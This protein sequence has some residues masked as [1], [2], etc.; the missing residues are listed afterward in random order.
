[1]GTLRVIGFFLL[2]MSLI[3]CQGGRESA[4][5]ADPR[6]ES[7]GPQF[8]N[9]R[10]VIFIP[11]DENAT[12]NTLVATVDARPGD[13]IRFDCGYYE[14]SQG[15]VIQTTEDVTIE[16]CGIDKTV[17]S[18]K[19]S[20]LTPEGI[21]INNARGIVIRGL[22]VL[23]TAGDGIKLKGVDHGTLDH[24]RT[25]WSSGGGAH[26]EDPVDAENYG[27]AMKVA[28]TN[29]PTVA[30]DQTINQ[31]NPV[32]DTTSPDYVP[33]RETGRYGIYPV[34]SRNILVT[35]SESIGA[36]DA[37]IYVGQTTNAIIR[38]SR[39]AYNVMGFEIENVQG[40]E[41]DNNIAE[42]NT[43]GFLIYDLDGLD[44]YGYGS[45]AINNVS[46]MNNTY[47]F[48]SGGFVGNVPA[49][50]GFITLSYDRMDIY[51]NR[52]ENNNTGGF[53]W[54][55]YALF[56]ASD[57]PSETQIDYFTEGV[58][59]YDN[60][61]VNN[62]NQLSPP[63]YDTLIASQG[64]DV[65]TAMPF[66]VGIKNAIALS[67][68]TTVPN[69]DPE[70]LT[71][72]TGLLS[73]AG[74][75][76]GHILW[77][78][79]LDSY[80][81]DCPYPTD[82]DG[83]PVPQAEYAPGKPEYRNSHGNPDCRYNAYKFDTKASGAPRIEPDWLGCIADSNDFS[84][85]SI[86]FTNFHGT[87]G[88]ELLVDQN[89]IDPARLATLAASHDMSAFDCQTRFGHMLDPVP[90]V[91]I[92]P[93]QP[94][95]AIAPA[96]TDEYVA[97]LCDADVGRNVNFDAA[98]EVNCPKLQDYNLFDDPEDPTS[99]PLSNGVP[100]VLN[101][102][103][104]TEYAVK[105]RVAYLPP[106]KK[107]QYRDYG[108][109]SVN[110]GILWPTGT[111]LAK[112]FSTADEEKGTETP[113]ETRLMIKRRNPDGSQYWTGMA[114]IWTEK[115]GQWSADLSKSGALL[116]ISWNYTD[117]ATGVK[118]KGSTDEYVVPHIN[119]CITCHGNDDQEVGSAPVGPKVR[120]LNRPYRSE[121]PFDTAQANHSVAGVNQIK[122]LCDNNLMIDCP[123]LVIDPTT[124]NAVNIER[125]P[126]FNLPGDSGH[127]AGSDADVEA[128]AR[129]YLEVNCAHCHNPKGAASNT[130]VYFDVFRKVDIQYGICKGPTAAGGEGSGGRPHDIHPGDA[131]Q[132]IIPF[133][134][135][136]LATS[137]AARMPPLARSVV[138]EE[139]VQLIEQW[140]N[141]VITN[142]EARYPNSTSCQ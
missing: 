124:Q 90:P 76:G 98:L 13:T 89:N 24:I 69:L 49:G 20:T 65:N 126:A 82:Q 4:T 137:A 63:D 38:N 81:A 102:K 17:L 117:P 1:M 85:D 94:S 130:G 15:L 60:V 101:S 114:Y 109:F 110:D 142:D 64:N 97:E 95:G 8:E 131:S 122:F 50:T 61:F 113:I 78:G 3:A 43:G 77:D 35:D 96:P 107:A 34:A 71:S 10:R 48:N 39:A 53:I 14:L 62:G 46:R 67:L 45:R 79:L 100:F 99:T 32:A 30:P 6:T 25:M 22:T 112:T 9:G 70:S 80:N 75:R 18:F 29:P 111:I 28:C 135:G 51:N 133:R 27:Y 16:G 37:G 115:D 44:Q 52:I 7:N 93:F 106:G 91:V 55:S 129:S 119:Q 41:Y 68:T 104:F 127:P 73:S 140:I 116:N 21:F 84:D 121:S 58:Q 19:T 66:L 136:P 118:H 108:D 33:S 59:I 26:S 57:Q 134:I 123:D 92:P 105:Y 12:T 83:N 88:L 74:F 86:V 141:T 47:N 103:L 72:V 31:I 54:A 5:N 120:N 2:G 23:D 138:D 56:P 42:C 132:S 139:A 128:R 87:D 125:N 36:S 11:N 40:G